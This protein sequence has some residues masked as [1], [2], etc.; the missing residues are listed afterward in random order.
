MLRHVN[1]VPTLPWTDNEFLYDVQITCNIQGCP[2]NGV[3]FR[4]SEQMTDVFVLVETTEPPPTYVL[5]L[6][7]NVPIPFY[8]APV[9]QTRIVQ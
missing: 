6:V 3:M 5:E 7:V 2:Y 1:D 9:V 8:D 4:G